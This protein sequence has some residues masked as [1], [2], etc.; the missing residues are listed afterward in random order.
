MTSPLSRSL[1]DIR[2]QEIRTLIDA[3]GILT[4]RRDGAEAVSDH[5][6]ELL[7]WALA[8]IDELK[9]EKDRL[10]FLDTK[11]EEVAGFDEYGQPI[12]LGHAWGMYGQCH[13][14]REAID[15]AMSTPRVIDDLPALSSPKM[16]A[17]T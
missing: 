13:A 15:K 10:D 1:E 9:K 14:I 16:G 3:A 7:S 6:R 12:L 8:R 4:A 2:E 11:R 17:P 5:T